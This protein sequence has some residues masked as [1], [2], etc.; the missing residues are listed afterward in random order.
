M[1]VQDRVLA[2]SGAELHRLDPTV[3]TLIAPASA[4]VRRG[5]TCGGTV[6]TGLVTRSSG[7]RRSPKAQVRAA[8]RYELSCISVGRT[9]AP[10]LL[11]L[12]RWGDSATMLCGRAQSH[13]IDW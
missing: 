2:A 13:E 3:V 4:S 6:S 7:Y 12:I 8:P 10:P 9:C 1:T 5:R 11:G